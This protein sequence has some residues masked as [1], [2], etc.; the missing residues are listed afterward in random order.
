MPAGFWT[1]SLPGALVLAFLMYLLVRWANDD[2]L[3]HLPSLGTLSSTYQTHARIAKKIINQD[4]GGGRIMCMWDDCEQQATTLY[5]YR[6]CRHDP[7]RTC[8]QAET[9]ARG[10]GDAGAHIWMAFCMER[11][12]LYFRYSGGWRAHQLLAEGGRAYGNLPRGSKGM[13]R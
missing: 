9:L 1:I 12:L 7:G 13:I 6:E 11:H 10:H 8:D 4:N 5:Q 2:P 3:F